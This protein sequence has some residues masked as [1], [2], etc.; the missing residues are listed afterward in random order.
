[1]KSYFLNLFTSLDYLLSSFLMLTLLLCQCQTESGVSVNES[2][3]PIQ[4]NKT[5]VEYADGFDLKPLEVGYI[6]HFYRFSNEATDTISTLLL[7]KGASVP[8]PYEHISTIEVPVEKVAVL[9]SSYV[10]YFDFVGAKEHIRAIS[11]VRYVYNEDI[12]QNV[13]NG[14]IKEVGFGEALDK[15]QLLALNIDLVLDIGWPDSPNKN[16]QILENLGIPQIII[17]EWQ[18]STLLGRAE[19]VKIIAA[20]TGKDDYAANKFHEI[21]KTYDSLAQLSKG[22]IEI[23]E[24]ICNLPYKGSWFVPGGDS[25]MSK[26]LD[27]AAGRYLWSDDEGTGGLKLDF[28][29]VY[30]KGVKAD[31]WVNPGVVQSIREIKEKDVRLADFQS[32]QSGEVYNSINKTK[33]GQANDYWESGLVNPHVILA[34]MLHILHPELIPDHQLVYFRKIQ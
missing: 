32:V 34:D 33:R 4:D 11:E 19:W 18:E 1:M 15:E 12:Y 5:S 30:A 14:K 23:P 22:I 26:L 27:D 9:H 25:Y 17:T 28:E 7:Q 13:Q 21:A 20:L 6:L 10:S 8:I 16:S 31:F 29:S 3:R 24:I 2:Q